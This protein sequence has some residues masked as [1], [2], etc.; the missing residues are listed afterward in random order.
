MEQESGNAC[1]FDPTAHKLV[2]LPDY[3]PPG[4][5]RFYEYH[6]HVCVDG[7]PDHLRLNLCLT[8]DGQF[9]TI[10]FGLLEKVLVES[11]FRHH[12][13]E[14]VDYD[15]P[16]FRGYIES[17]DGAR[18]ILQALRVDRIFPQILKAEPTQG[19]ISELLTPPP[20]ASPPG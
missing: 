10:W 18:H 6:N 4:G 17:E 9:V 8:Q 14:P 7:K 20:A 12:G 16:L 2:P 3:R 13:L 11:W 19:I 15:E 5:V 1:P